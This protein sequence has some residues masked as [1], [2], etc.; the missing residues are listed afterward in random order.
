MLESIASQAP[1][2]VLIFIRIG[3]FM[4]FVPFFNNNNYIMQAKVGFV[5][6]LTMLLFPAIPKET[7]TVPGHLPGLLLVMT[8]EVVVGIL[9]GLTFLI[10]LSALQLAG[11]MV[12]FQMAFSMANAADPAFGTNS[13]VL[14]VLLVLVGTMIFISLRGDHYMLYSLMRSFDILVPGTIVVTHNLINE[15][16]RM[17]LKSFEVGFKLASPAV[18]LLLCIDV[19]LGLIGKTA[20]KMQIFFVGLPLKIAVGLFSVTLIMGF[21]LTIWGKEALRFPEYIFRLFQFM[22]I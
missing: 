18:V 4:A 3:A 1:L 21:V 19:T 16:S 13:N 8:M 11:R 12:G 2:F 6:F 5:F 9:M 14:S 17:I 22:R 10:I 7:W 15:L 20:S